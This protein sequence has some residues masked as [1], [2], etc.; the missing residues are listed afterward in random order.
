MSISVEIINFIL[1]FFVLCQI[2]GA[3]MKIKPIFDEIRETFLVRK[4]IEK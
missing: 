2:V 4:R 1:F 3:Y